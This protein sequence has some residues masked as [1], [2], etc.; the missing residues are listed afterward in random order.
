MK[1]SLILILTLF[2]ILTKPVLG[3]ITLPPAQATFSVGNIVLYPTDDYTHTNQFLGLFGNENYLNIQWNA[4]YN[5][6]SK[7]P[8]G[9]TCWLNCPYS[10]GDIEK[11]CEA[12]QSCSYEGET[13]KGSC[14]ISNPKY[15]YTDKNVIVCKFYDPNYPNVVYLPYPNRTFMM[16]SF[17]VSI[18]G[19]AFTVGGLNS[20]PISVTSYSFL[21]SQYTV[22][23]SSS[24]P[25]IIIQNSNPYTEEIGYGE[26]GKVYPKIGFE[27][28]V[29]HETIRVLVRPNKDPT[30]CS[31]SSQCP[32][33]VYG[34]YPVCFEGKC[35]KEYDIPVSSGYA[36]MPEY[37]FRGFLQLM[38]MSIALFALVVWRRKI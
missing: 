25:Y 2:F 24:S 20:W 35:W 16:F 5:P 36:S 1:K 37:D 17:S 7:D 29:D 33:K 12:Y 6:P 38:F 31:A 30:V 23:L 13:G 21:T 4:E 27:T 32:S 15:N 26:V 9:V 34:R 28:I 11:V 10:G 18:S 14:T 8:I 3:E 19:G 22:N